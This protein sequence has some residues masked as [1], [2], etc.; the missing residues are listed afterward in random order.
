MTA[1]PGPLE[2]RLRLSFALVSCVLVALPLL[3]VS[4]PPITD[5]PQHTAQV[6]LFLET[7]VAI[8][9][10]FERAGLTGLRPALDAL[11]ASQRVIG[12]AFARSSALIRI[13]PFVQTFAY[14]QVLKGGELSFSFAEF[15]HALVAYKAPRRPPWTPALEWLPWGVQPSDLSHF[16]YAIVAASAELHAQ[17]PERLPVT[18]VT[19]AGTWR[20]Y[21]VRR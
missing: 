20:L 5:L 1:P 17:L 16:D 18:P 6:R 15:R 21:R 10:T 12:L 11:P 3:A 4:Y 2:A 7:L 13:S 9:T 19:T 14:A 8:W